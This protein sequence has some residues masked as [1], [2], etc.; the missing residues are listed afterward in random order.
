MQVSATQAALRLAQG[1]G[2]LIRSIDDRGVVAVLDSRLAT[3]RYGDFI[4]ASLPP[5]WH[6][7]DAGIARTA[8]RR[9]AAQPGTS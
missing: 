4:R 7:T 9:L 1:S 6:T 5:M 2:R 3:A 8:L